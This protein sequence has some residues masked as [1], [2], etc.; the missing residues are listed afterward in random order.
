MYSQFDPFA[1]RSLRAEYQTRREVSE[2]VTRR[3]WHFG[4]NPGTV[5]SKK[6]PPKGSIISQTA[7]AATNRGLCPFDGE[8]QKKYHIRM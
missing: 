3:D 4:A 7:K 5:T 2:L 1:D 6:W 8:S